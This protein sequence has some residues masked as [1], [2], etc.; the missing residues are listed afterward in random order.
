MSRGV[1]VLLVSAVTVLVLAGLVALLLPVVIPSL[2][3]RAQ[4]VLG[5]TI[6]TVPGTVEELIEATGIDGAGRTTSTHAEADEEYTLAAGIWPW[7]LPPGW[8][9]PQNRGVPDTPGRHWNGMGVAG[10]FSTWATETLEAVQSGGLSPDAVNALLD[11]VEDATRTLLDA[12]VL[13][14]QRFIATSVTPLRP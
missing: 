3:S 6:D 8:K 13:S 10:A 7:E 14:D 5:G 1:R 9:F 12:G 11:E 4:V 2:P